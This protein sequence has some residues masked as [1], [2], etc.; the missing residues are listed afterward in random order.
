MAIPILLVMEKNRS[1]KFKRFGKSSYQLLSTA[2]YF[3]LLL[4]FKQQA[5]KFVA[6]PATDHVSATDK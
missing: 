6:S 2:S 5:H 3:S 1:I 4:D